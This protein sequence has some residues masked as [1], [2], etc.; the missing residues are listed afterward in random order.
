MSLDSW[1]YCQL[2]T[3]LSLIF[4]V[5]SPILPD[6]IAKDSDDKTHL[7]RT[8]KLMACICK[9]SNILSLE[10]LEKS[11]K[12]QRPLDVDNFLLLGDKQ[13]EEKYNFSMK[14]TLENG[15]KVRADR[16]GILG[17]WDVYICSGVAGNKAPSA[18]ELQLI[19]EAAGGQWLKSLSNSNDPL[20]TIIITSDPS[21]KSQLKERGVPKAEGQG[22]KLLTT[23][24]LFHTVITQ[25]LDFDTSGGPVSNPSEKQRSKRKAPESTSSQAN[26][27]KASRKR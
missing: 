8:P 1:H 5:C 24:W 21:T 19:V 12:E 4:T 11:N 22:A 16:G 23:T 10:W 17:G 3:S 9:T 26:R 15:R 6:V 18:R 7:R 25:R 13:A 20:K 2:G 14:Q 27:R